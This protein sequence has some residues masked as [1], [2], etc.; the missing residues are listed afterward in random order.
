MTFEEAFAL[1]DEII[2][3]ARKKL[4]ALQEQS[5]DPQQQEA[6]NAMLIQAEL[7]TMQTL[8]SRM[9]RVREAFAEAVATDFVTPPEPEQI[10]DQPQEDFHLDPAVLA[11]FQKWEEVL[12]DRLLAIEGG[13]DRHH[14]NI[15]DH[16]GVI[17]GLEKMMK[18]LSAPPPPP[19]QVD[20][21]FSKTPRQKPSP[22]RR[23]GG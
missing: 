21:S 17:R 11:D 19:Q 1:T 23:W 5:K 20:G 22:N 3:G 10:A 15:A 14:E 2:E 4:G 16:E 13:L 8:H 18:D 6:G 9:I 7:N 12:E